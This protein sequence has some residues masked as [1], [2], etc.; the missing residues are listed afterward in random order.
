M[1]KK[2][3]D[4]NDLLERV[5]ILIKNLQRRL[6]LKTKKKILKLILQRVRRVR[7]LR[8]LELKRIFMRT[9]KRRKRSKDHRDE[10]SHQRHLLEDQKRSRLSPGENPY[11]ELLLKG[12]KNLRSRLLR[13]L[14]LR[15]RRRRSKMVRRVFLELRRQSLRKR[16]RLS[17]KTVRKRL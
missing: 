7:I 12:R 10:H 1:K 11:K 17:E 13:N 15:R 9:Q 5:L 8:R 3:S 6:K 2:R 14:F 4:L 16:R